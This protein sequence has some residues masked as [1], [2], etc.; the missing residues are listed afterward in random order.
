[1]DTRQP[2]LQR[3]ATAFPAHHATTNQQY[4]TREIQFK[5]HSSQ[6]SDPLR[7]GEGEYTHTHYCHAKNQPASLPEA[8]SA[9]QGGGA[10]SA[11]PRPQQCRANARA[12]SYENE[13]IRRTTNMANT[14]LLPHDEPACL[15]PGSSLSNTRRGRAERPTQATTV[16]R[17]REGHLIRE[18]R[19]QANNKHGRHA[20]MQSTGST[21]AGT[22]DRP[23]PTNPGGETRR[24]L[25]PRLKII[26]QKT[27]AAT[28]RA[29]TTPADKTTQHTLI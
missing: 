6:I 29:R 25:T 21:S 15:T 17:E 5:S 28:R 2:T 27:Q 19:H 3:E 7:T 22:K 24:Q 20:T 8:R 10:R 23:R 18:R 4:A 11:Q 9:I 14:Q 16:P 1:M 12:T 26:P 13:D